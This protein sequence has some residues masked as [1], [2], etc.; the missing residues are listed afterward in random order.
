MVTGVTPALSIRLIQ[1]WTV[2]GMIE[3]SL[4]GPNSPLNAA[5]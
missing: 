2:E 4:I 1:P 3:F 5:S